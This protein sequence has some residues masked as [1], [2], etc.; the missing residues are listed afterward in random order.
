MMNLSAG[1]DGANRKNTA[2]LT[3]VEAKS[4]ETKHLVLKMQKPPTEKII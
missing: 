1:N 4:R 3:I 2:K